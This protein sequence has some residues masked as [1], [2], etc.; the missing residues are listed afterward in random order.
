MSSLLCALAA[1]GTAPYKSVATPGWTL[2]EQGRA[3]SKQ[4]GNDVDPADIAKRLGGE[5]VRLWVASV[6]FREDVVGSEK[7]MQRI[8]ENYKKIRN[9]FRYILGNLYDFDPGLNAVGFSELQPIDQYMLRQTAD[10]TRDVLRWYEEFGFHK[11]YQRVNN[12]CVVEL[13]AFY[14]DVLKDRLYTSAPN[15][16]ARRSAQTVIWKI[17]E[18]LVRLLTPIMSFT[19][20]EVWKLLPS[21]GGRC[22]SVHLSTFLSP[23]QILGGAGEQPA[24]ASAEWETLHKVRDQVL[25][26]LEDA[27]NA[28]LIGANLEAQ[29]KLTASESLYPVLERHQDDLRYLFIVSSV[30]LERSASGNGTGGL[31]VE[32]G[33]ARGQKCERCWNYSTAVGKDP[34][35]PTV[36][37]RCSAVLR[38]LE[39]GG[40]AASS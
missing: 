7:L 28:K 27:R 13:S 12:F 23:E 18:A 35:Y 11:I 19:C 32:V 25:K 17:G 6:D 20:E 16:R 26:A 34:S 36:C 37:E 15:S 31:A 22:P 24:G 9:T 39:N 8:A 5:I 2:D 4:H 29:V 21:A 33:K 3:M 14:F 30:G 1:R 40:E 38:E 10:M